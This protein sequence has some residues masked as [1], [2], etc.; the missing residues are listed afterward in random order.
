VAEPLL[1][2][3]GVII[4]PMTYWPRIQDICRRYGV[5]LVVDEVICGFGRTGRMWGCD[6]FEIEPDV[7]TMAKGLT[8]GYLPMSAVGLSDEIADEIRGGGVLHHGF[9]YSGHP[10]AAAVA[11]ANLR[12]ID[13]EKL[14]GR[15]DRETGPR[16]AMHVAG[17]SR[18]P[19][20][21]EARSCG[22]IAGFEIVRSKAARRRF[23]PAMRAASVV[24]DACYQEG[25]V[26]RAIR[27]GFALCPPLS[28]TVGQLD[29]LVDRLA[30]GLDRA[31][32]ALERLG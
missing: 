9:T 30:A 31:T 4:P 21:G 29:E 28:I 7:I 22:L 12:V 32:H 13:D 14:I 5:L 27:E 11:V 3:G 24:R 20:I 19:L 2:A 1:G 8:S 26:V 15:V 23:E 10:V 17:I 16:L 25:L 6:T 18:H